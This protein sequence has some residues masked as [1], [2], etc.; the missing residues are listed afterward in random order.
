MAEIP[1]KRCKSSI[2]PPNHIVVNALFQIHVSTIRRTP[3]PAH[4]KQ[5]RVS[6]L[7]PSL[8]PSQR[9]SPGQKQREG[10]HPVNLSVQEQHTQ[11]SGQQAGGGAQEQL[12][13]V[14]MLIRQRQ[15]V[16]TR[17]NVLIHGQLQ[18]VQ[19][20]I[21]QRQLVS[22]RQNVLIHGQLQSVQML[23]RQRQ[24]VSTRQNVLIHGQLQSVQMLIRQRQLVSTRQ[25]VLI[26]GQLQSVQIYLFSPYW[27]LKVKLIA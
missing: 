9:R 7:P 6:P 13:S 24:L 23:I 22:T 11:R 5:D 19:M 16:S 17:Q 10:T 4:Q 3:S 15:L 26:H 1:L 21:R 20:L 27:D 2:Q 18:S 12:Q 8:S 25:N 14:Q